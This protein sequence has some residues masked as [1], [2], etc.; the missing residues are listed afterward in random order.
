MTTKF[1]V[2]ETLG[3]KPPKGAVPT[4]TDYDY[5]L[6]YRRAFEV[7]LWSL[8]AVQIYGFARAINTVGGGPNVVMSW[9]KV[10]ESNAELLTA[11]NTTPYIL[12]YTDLSKGPVVVDVPAASAKASFY[13]QI[14]SH[15]QFA[16][17]DVGPTGLDK[18]Q[19]GKYLLLPPGYDGEV[20]EGY[21]VLE[22]PSFR[23]YFAFRS[24]RGKGSSNEDAIEY[25]RTLKMYYLND[26]QPTKFIDPA[27]MRFPTLSRYDERWFHDVYEIFS[28]EPVQEQDKIMMFFLSTLGIEKGKPFNPDKTAEKAM[29]QAAIDAYYYISHRVIYPNADKFYWPDRKWQNVLTPDKN[30]LFSF[31][32]DD[33]I[34]IDNRAERYYLGTFYPRG[35]FGKPAAM[36]M[37]TFI[38]KDGNPLESGKLY[39]LTVPANVPVEYFWSLIIYDRE[40]LSFIYTKE[41][42]QGLSTYDMPNMKKNEDGSVTLYFGPFPPDGMESNW[43]PTNCKIPM[44]TMRFYGPKD[45]FLDKRW[46]MPDVELA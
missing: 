30:N 11:N 44:P 22:S 32:Y 45:E 4:L 31:V 7:A 23:V 3:G 10:A 34:D 21:L 5:E 25:A 36:Y 39:K 2:P 14:V 29:R 13:G 20:P 27:D 19:G 38:D 8:P 15:W 1:N 17:A 42:R 18:G 26:P 28:I 46:S 40:K 41:N 43:I 35:M 33:F 16:M 9:S 12:A 6:K 24:I 37:F